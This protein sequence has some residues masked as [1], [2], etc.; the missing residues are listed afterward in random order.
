[1]TWLKRFMKD[2]DWAPEPGA[3]VNAALARLAT[4]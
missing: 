4:P 3:A 2:W 1:M